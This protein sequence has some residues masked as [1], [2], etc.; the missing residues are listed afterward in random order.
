MVAEQARA[1]GEIRLERGRGVRGGMCGER[2]VGCQGGGMARCGGGRIEQPAILR[3]F[4]CWAG[5]GRM[6]VRPARPV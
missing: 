6:F 1:D 4:V 5:V 3:L 2:L